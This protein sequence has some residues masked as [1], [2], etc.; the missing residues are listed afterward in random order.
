MTS[1]DTEPAG[2][3]ADRQVQPASPDAGSDA[4]QPAPAPEPGSRPARWLARV[5]RWLPLPPAVWLLTALWALIMACATLL[6]PAT[7]GLD[8]PQHI[9]MAYAYSRSLH[10]YAPGERP[11]SAA[12]LK[13]Q[14]SY[15]S[16][17]PSGPLGDSPIGPRGSRPTLAELGPPDQPN[18]SPNVLPNQMVQHP[19]AYYLLAAAVLRVPGVGHLPFDQQIGLM[20]LVSLL[21]LLPLPALCWAT[22]RR[23][24]ASAPAALAAAAL[25]LSLP[26]LARIGG[27]VTNDSLLILLTGV[28]TYLLARV[29]TGDLGRRT[30]AAVAVV[31]A[32]D[33]LTKGFALVL[34]P[35]VLLAYLIGWRR[36]GRPFPLVPLIAVAAGGAV[37]GAWWLRNLLDYHAVQPSGFGAGIEP[38]LYGAPHAGS[39]AVFVPGFA[40]ALAK[41]I[42][43]E[44]GFPEPPLEPAALTY[45]WLVIS[46]IAILAAL[47]L[48][49][50]PPLS[51]AVAA[52]LTLPAVLA[53]LLAT[54]QSAS[55]FRRYDVFTGVQGR[56]GYQGLVGLCVL[57]AVGLTQLTSPL[58][59]R[60]LAAG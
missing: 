47:L 54:S 45:G 13:V 20:R 50:P 41:R 10:V 7:Y 42:W 29:L 23:L 4:A 51:R 15:R 31:L 30:A 28:L 21:L 1:A 44:L 11:V 35:V 25:P 56:Y 26:G 60:G 12:V 17:P 55:T 53:L 38:R 22:G 9:D 48:R 58:V 27:A 8:E 3:A 43:G 6:W 32:A 16:F 14:F 36:S 39:L 18:G 49:R 34:P 52:V 59:H 19:P 57:V 5:R 40:D 46:C 2:L 33:L 24:G 37:G